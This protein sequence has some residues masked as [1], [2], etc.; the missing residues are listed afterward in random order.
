MVES[1]REDSIGDNN[2]EAPPSAAVNVPVGDHDTSVN[3]HQLHKVKVV[4][5]ASSDDVQ[6][7][8]EVGETQSDRASPTI[9]RKKKPY[10]KQTFS[11]TSMV[12]RLNAANSFL[13]D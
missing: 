6:L 7:L 2:I 13:N 9:Q 11:E 4:S 3:G 8:P 1:T 10:S 12:T 5:A